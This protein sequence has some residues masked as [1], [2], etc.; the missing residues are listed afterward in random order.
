M[1]QRY[2]HIDE[3]KKELGLLPKISIED[4]RKLNQ[5]IR[6]EFN[7]NSNH[8]EGNTLTYGETELLLI[9]G[10]TTGNHQLR[11]FEEIKG[12]DL[13][14]EMIQDWANDKERSL[15]ELDI[16]TLNKVLL[17][18]PF[19]KEALTEDGQSTRRKI[20]VGEYKE[21]PNS[22][23][24]QNGE[25]FHY[26][27]PEETPAK[28]QELFV[29]L[30][31][32]KKKAD[33]H[34]IEIAT[35][36][37]HKFVLIHPFDDGNGRVSRLIL[38]YIL[39]KNGYPP[40][41][42]KSADKKN[43]LNALNK[44]DTGD[45]YAFVDYVAKEV[46]W[47]FDLYLKATKGE[48]LKENEDWEKEIKVLKKTGENAPN[49]RSF[50]ST[51]DRWVE[52]IFPLIQAID[53]KFKGTVGSL[54]ESS[55][56]KVILSKERNKG[57]RDFTAHV[58]LLD[59]SKIQERFVDVNSNQFISATFSFS[60]YLKNGIDSFDITLYLL[61]TFTQFSYSIDLNTWSNTKVKNSIDQNLNDTQVEMIINQ[62]GEE[63]MRIIN[64]NSIK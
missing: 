23:R 51:V 7:Y 47:S 32:E 22:V 46:E 36:F 26:T 45:I 60:N 57:G 16:R 38:N 50:E 48:E 27:S 37:H 63:A 14:F 42:I 29:W 8:I 1:K 43:Y 15:T 33:L 28:M 59:K 5:K 19:W 6:L 58:K 31:E 18:R 53:N 41:I 39:I 2:Q 25:I 24:L 30:N 9:F 34:P 13:A 44:A 3:L 21:Y 54:F 10:K 17:V 64:I 40:I 35:I 11:E 20:K 62:L 49:R 56:F 52:S 61:L 12:H 4:Q 55:D